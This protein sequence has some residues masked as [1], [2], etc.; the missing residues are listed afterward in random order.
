LASSLP[1]SYKEG[2]A[3]VVAVEPSLIEM[4]SPQLFAQQRG[5]TIPARPIRIFLRAAVVINL[6]LQKRAESHI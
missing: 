4:A 6:K 1:N 5:K 3:E 2:L